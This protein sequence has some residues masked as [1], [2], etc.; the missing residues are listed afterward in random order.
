MTY[1][2][3]ERRQ[4]CTPQTGFSLS[5]LGFPLSPDMNG[6]YRVI[7]AD[8]KCS[9]FG[10]LRLGTSM[11]LD[12]PKKADRPGGVR[13]TK[14]IYASHMTDIYI[15]LLSSSLKAI[16]WV[17]SAWTSD[18]KV[19]SDL[20]ALQ[21]AETRRV[22]AGVSLAWPVKKG[23]EIGTEFETNLQQSSNPL[24][25]L[26]NRSLYLTLRWRFA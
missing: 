26:R 13:E 25:T 21:P 11:G 15:P 23:W 2:F 12:R 18:N 20:L 9:L 1:I 7:R 5:E 6:T 14:E 16:T 4:G 8:V 22:D 3:D 24:L 17:R 19:F 10:E